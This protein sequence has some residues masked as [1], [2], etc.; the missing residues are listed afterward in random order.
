[1]A[2]RVGRAPA[3]EG[4]GEEREIAG[5]EVIAE[6]E[7]LREA[8]ARPARVVPGPVRPLRPEQ[9]LEPADD[10]R[11]LQVAEGKQGHEG[12]RGL[13]RRGRTDAL[14]GGIVVR[15]GQLAPA[16]VGVLARVEPVAGPLVALAAHVLA[17]LLEPAEREPRAVEVVAAPA[18]V[19]SS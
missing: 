11:G 2:P 15:A 12:P 9:V 19:P 8:S 10:A 16:P 4:E 18:S 1:R 7:D 17:R 3:V 14:L 13:R 5:V 6:V